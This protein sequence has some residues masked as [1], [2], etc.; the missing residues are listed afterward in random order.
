MSIFRIPKQTHLPGD[1][2]INKA[3]TNY[4]CEEDNKMTQKIKELEMNIKQVRDDVD[5]KIIFKFL[6]IFIFLSFHRN[7]CMH[8]Y[9]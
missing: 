5:L 9:W 8:D 2:E 1:E 4:S 3:I 7:E 6:F